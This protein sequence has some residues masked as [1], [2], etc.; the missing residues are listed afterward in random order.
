MLQTLI[1]YVTSTRTFLRLLSRSGTLVTLCCDDAVRNC[2]S[3]Y[4][5][6]MHSRTFAGVLCNDVVR[7]CSFVCDIGRLGNILLELLSVNIVIVQL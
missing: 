3:S 2:S 7:N 6:V 5:S 1:G 4:S